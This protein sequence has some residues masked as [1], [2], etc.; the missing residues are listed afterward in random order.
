MSNYLTRLT[1]RHFNFFR[2][3]EEMAARLRSV[4]Q[5]LI[6]SCL[7]NVR[8]QIENYSPPEMDFWIN[9]MQRTQ[10]FLSYLGVEGLWKPLLELRPVKCSMA[11]PWFAL[12]YMIEV[13]SLTI[14][15]LKIHGWGVVFVCNIYF[16]PSGNM[17]V[18]LWNNY[19]GTF[20]EI[21]DY[22][23]HTDH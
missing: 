4:H 7:K 13:I 14:N 20:T 15:W 10:L 11:F 6:E 21:Q 23:S 12:I 8:K 19:S 3:F 22:F 17:H 18:S 9:W 5:H 2:D 1:K 16:L